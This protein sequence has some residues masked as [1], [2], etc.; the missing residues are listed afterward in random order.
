MVPLESEH[1]FS[2]LSVIKSKGSSGKCWVF[3]L[4][5]KGKISGYLFGGGLRVI[6]KLY[7]VR[8]MKD[9]FFWKTEIL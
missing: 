4:D 9:N 1:P 3:H 8:N 5:C 2:S 6:K 7:I